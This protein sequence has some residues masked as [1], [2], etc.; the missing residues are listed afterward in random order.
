MVK[1]ELQQKELLEKLKL[2]RRVFINETYPGAISMIANIAFTAKIKKI[3]KQKEKIIKETTTDSRTCMLSTCNGLLTVDL[4]CTTCQTTFCKACE[5]RK[6]DN[7][8]CDRND[9]DSI[10]LIHK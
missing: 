8:Q 10:N 3:E 6:T 9:L 2:E 1:K 5:K 4:V 7:H